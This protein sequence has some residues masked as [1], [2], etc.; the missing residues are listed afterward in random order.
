MALLWLGA[1]ALPGS[2]QPADTPTEPQAVVLHVSNAKAS[3]RAKHKSETRQPT[4]SSGATSFDQERLELVPALSLLLDGSFYHPNLIDFNLFI[5]AGLSYEDETLKTGS[6]DPALARE[7][8]NPLQTYSF[9]MRFLK[10]KPNRL[11]LFGDKTELRRNNDFFS[12]YTL[13]SER[14]GGQIEIIPDGWPMTFSASHLDEQEYDTGR[15]RRLV[16]D[17]LEFKIS[18]DRRPA[19]H[20]RVTVRQEDFRREE[21]GT[22]S[23]EGTRRYASLVDWQSFGEDA[24]RLSTDARYNDVESTAI[25]STSLSVRERVTARHSETLDSRYEYLF[26]DYESGP[27]QS[28]LHQGIASLRHQLYESLTSSTEIEYRTMDESGLTAQRLGGGFDERYTKRLGEAGRLTLGASVRLY[29][30][31]RETRNTTPAITDER[32]ALRDGEIAV[33]NQTIDDPA[34]LTV[35]DPTG[36]ILYRENL[37]YRVVQRGDAL[38]L[39]R[40]VGGDIPNGGTVIVS[41]IA[42]G[43]AT[44][45]FTTREDRYQCRIDVLDGLLAVYARLNITDHSGGELLVLHNVT[46]QV[47][48][49]ET[50]WHWLHAGAE[51]RD[52]DSSLL[53]YSSVR[54]FEDFVWRTTAGSS[55]RLGLSQMWTTY[56][57]T[58]EE[59][60]TLSWITHYRTH[61]TRALAFNAEGGVWR[62]RGRADEALDRDLVTARTDLDYWIGQTTVRAGYEY[63]NEETL[64]EDRRRHLFDVR[65][66]RLF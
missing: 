53:P 25:P 27:A 6:T 36:T 35:T 57:E 15:P 12:R 45:R 65:V 44:D 43:Q 23:L 1:R 62:E 4:G 20:T 42:S 8:T 3:L 24:I 41:Y 51:Y 5:E 2:G 64:G 48:G 14:Y 59:I 56:P 29:D 39:E 38:G 47:L 19:G 22:I 55:L 18:N 58:D 66:E 61:F 54:F 28:T 7:D 46:E 16:E 17:D 37:D 30:E 60:E 31:D 10:E 63:Q 32:K 11:S 40:V 9:D 13:D 50:S 34:S 49:A 33:L 26:S 52:Y 21:E